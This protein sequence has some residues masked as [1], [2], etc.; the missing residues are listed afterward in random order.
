MSWEGVVDC[1]S[2]TKTNEFPLFLLLRTSAL[3][4]EEFTVFCSLCGSRNNDRI[5]STL[6]F[7]QNKYIELS[8]FTIGKN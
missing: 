4:P 6:L 8:K 1:V 7:L 2:G 5:T 3:N